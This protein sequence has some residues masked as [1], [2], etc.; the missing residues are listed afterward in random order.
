MEIDKNQSPEELA[1]L[2]ARVR[3]EELPSSP[4][5]SA[6][7]NMLWDLAGAAPP[8]SE[9][10]VLSVLAI[11]PDWRES[12][13]RKWLQKDVVPPPLDLHNMVAFLANRLTPKRA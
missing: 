4:G 10:R 11:N 6:R 8:Q 1:E 2:F 12:E 9:G 13:V 7:L 3:E 5:F